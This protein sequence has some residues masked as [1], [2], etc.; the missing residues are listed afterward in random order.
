MQDKVTQ[1]QIDK[2]INDADI[3]TYTLYEKCTVVTVRLKNGFVLTESSACVSKEN[4]NLEMGKEI[5]IGKIKD[6]LWELEGYYLQA[7]H[8]AFVEMAKTFMIPTHMINGGMINAASI[9]AIN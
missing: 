1:E 8:Y 2:L 4:Y 3:E 6:K 5:C 7:S 9:E